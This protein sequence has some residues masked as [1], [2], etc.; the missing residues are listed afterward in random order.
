M[1]FFIS[2]FFQEHDYILS[3]VSA[4]VKLKRNTSS[5]PIRDPNN[6]RIHMDVCLDTV[7]FCLNEDQYQSIIE[8]LKETE[9]YER[10]RKYRKWRPAIKVRN[11]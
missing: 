6:P 5:L 10:R 11:G 9:R 4:Q 3:P 8:W 1:M 2:I 7:A